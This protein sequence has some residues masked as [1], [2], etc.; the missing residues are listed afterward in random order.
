[1]KTHTI[2]KK[3][4]IA[5]ALLLVSAMCAQAQV[6]RGKGAHVSPAIQRQQPAEGNEQNQSTPQENVATERDKE[7]DGQVVRKLQSGPHGAG[8]NKPAGMH[9]ARVQPK[10]NR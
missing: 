9:Y 5:F 1:M 6:P 3:L 4:L 8:R 2:Y 7:V 10:I